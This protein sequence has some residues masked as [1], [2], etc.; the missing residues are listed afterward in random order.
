MFARTV[1]SSV[2][3]AALTVCAG[4][5]DDAEVS[6]GP[7]PDT[8]A[9]ETIADGD[10]GDGATATDAWVDTGPD[11]YVKPPGGQ[12]ESCETKAD[13]GDAFDCVA[14][15]GGSFCINTCVGATDCSSKFTCDLANASDT[16][17]HC[18]PPNYSC[19]G[20]LVSGCPSDQVCDAVTGK[21]VVG[22]VPCTP[23]NKISDCGPGLKC[24][25][26]ASPEFTTQKLCMPDCSDGSPCPG[27]SACQKSDAGNVCG[28]TGLACCYGNCMA[29]PGCATCGGKCILGMCVGCLLD[30]DCPGG[31]CETGSH[32]CVNPAGCPFDKPIKLGD[33]TCGQCVGN[34]DCTASQMCDLVGHACVKKPLECF[35][36]S[37]SY[38]DC[39]ALNNT[40]SCVECASDATCAAKKLGTC[41]TKFFT[42]SDDVTPTTGPPVGCKQDSDCKNAGLQAF[43]LACD[44]TITGLCYD[45]LGKCD[46]ISA[47]CNVKK[48]CACG[49]NGADLSVGKCT[50]GF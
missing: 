41:V 35:A 44:A 47:F 18:L 15:L 20:C 22:K 14:M 30:S 17:K 34:S 32:A 24:A 40:W 49:P 2:F 29:D 46:N 50:C 42:C 36:C 9:A 4:C 13:C 43:D 19:Q 38:P 28:F 11:T 27:G 23:C 21:C 5:G 16:V 12:C 26:L 7:S 39:V 25:S 10:A 37:A 31:H 8:E 6:G 1:V 33:G 45:K 48:G 3:A